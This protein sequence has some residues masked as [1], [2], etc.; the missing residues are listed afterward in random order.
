MVKK[1]MACLPGNQ[2]KNRSSSF[3]IKYNF[4]KKGRKNLH[5]Q[6]LVLKKVFLLKVASQKHNLGAPWEG[7]TPQAGEPKLK[8]EH[9]LVLGP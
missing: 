5:F 3:M 7:T 6:G 4:L 2:V 1:K 9:L 8:G